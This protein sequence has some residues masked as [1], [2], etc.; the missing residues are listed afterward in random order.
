MA[1][2]MSFSAPADAKSREY[3]WIYAVTLPAFI[4]V[5]LLGRLTPRRRL[6][7]APHAS[8][9]SEARATAHTII[10]FAFMH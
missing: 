8:L 3:R 9:L 4:V 5:A 10:P 6:P 7:G 2:S 1:S